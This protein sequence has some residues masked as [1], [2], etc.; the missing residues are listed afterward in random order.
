MSRARCHTCRQAIPSGTAS[1]IDRVA[2]VGKAHGAGVR[3]VGTPTRKRRSP[4][5]RSEASWLTT[6]RERPWLRRRFW[7]GILGRFAARA[8]HRDHV[9]ALV[10]HKRPSL[11]KNSDRNSANGL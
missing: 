11:L 6:R 7:T 4:A 10:S 3:G 8:D 2:H 5:S 9:L 1:V